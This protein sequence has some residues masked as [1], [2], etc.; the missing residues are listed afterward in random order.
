MEIP[1]SMDV[2]T[3]I[4]LQPLSGNRVA[5]AGEFVLLAGEVQPV[6][7]ALN[8][9]GITV[10]ATHTHMLNEEPR[11]YYLH[12]W[13]VGDPVAVAKGL[14]EAIDQTNVKTVQPALV[15]DRQEES[16]RHTSHASIS[17]FLSHESG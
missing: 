3:S 17:A 1:Q 2:A 4:R 8:R 14:R 10:T 5:A 9:N 6:M 7:K 11:L 13:A 12:L 15:A 16:P